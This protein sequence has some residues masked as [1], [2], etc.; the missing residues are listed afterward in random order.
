MGAF[1]RVMVAALA[2]IL[3]TL[4]AGC[5]WFDDTPSYRYRLTVEVDTPEGLKTGSSVIEVDT[6]TVRPG[7][8]PAS[9]GV[10]LRARGE[11]VVVDLPDGRTLF[12]LL[13][14]SEDSQWAA[15]V[16]LVL[17][18]KSREPFVEQ[19][20]NMMELYGKGPIALPRMWPAVGHL[21]RRSAYPMLV[22]FGDLDDPASVE[23]VDP[24]NLAAHF[25]EGVALRR[26]TVE[27]TDDP[28]T[29][30]IEKRLGWLPHFYDKM[31]DGQ[32]LN[33]S[34]A[35]ANNLSQGSFAKGT[36]D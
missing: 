14:S 35:L 13:Q 6:R 25:G 18:P 23:E 9:V 17:A 27:M 20:D 16:M 2:A 5:S 15:R 30:G 11:A 22:I 24:D 10:S 29:S 19:F 32:R 31:L 1:Y 34:R 33:N 4:C 8:S 3:A 7:S 28:V 12:A 21:P 26:I 36:I